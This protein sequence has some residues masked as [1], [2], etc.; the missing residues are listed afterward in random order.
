MSL[1][2]LYLSAVVLQCVLSESPVWGKGCLILQAILQSI[3]LNVFCPLVVDA[4]HHKYLVSIN[5][6]GRWK[7]R[8]YIDIY[9]QKVENICIHFVYFFQ[10][11]LSNII[12]FLLSFA[13]WRPWFSDWSTTA[14]P[15]VA[16]TISTRSVYSVA[17]CQIAR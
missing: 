14:E 11:K 3:P 1:N 12:I 8:N 6:S 9:I 5:F 4:S 17:R 13:Y 16:A 7:K 15:P 10:K 2:T